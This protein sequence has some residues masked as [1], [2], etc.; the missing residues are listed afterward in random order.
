MNETLIFQRG[1][2]MSALTVDELT[3]VYYEIL[4]TDTLLRQRM[5][6]LSDE[7]D[8]W[9]QAH[10]HLSDKT[11]DRCGPAIYER[12]EELSILLM[13]ISSHMDQLGAC[14]A[15]LCSETMRRAKTYA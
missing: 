1:I 11:F 9:S 7:G 6:Q 10:L 12:L 14:Y 8:F 3:D 13:T 2:D 15:D 4:S 5:K